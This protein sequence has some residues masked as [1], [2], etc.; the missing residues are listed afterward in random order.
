MLQVFTAALFRLIMLQETFGTDIFDV[1]LAHSCE[2]LVPDK[3]LLTGML[4]LQELDRFFNGGNALL[5]VDDG[6]PRILELVTRVQPHVPFKNAVHA[7]RI[8]PK[9]CVPLEDLFDQLRA[10][11]R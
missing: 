2:P 4:S 3:C 8:G 1:V 10:R 7:G 6:S 5:G 9:I 11:V